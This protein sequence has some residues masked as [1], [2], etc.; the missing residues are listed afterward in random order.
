MIFFTSPVDE[1]HLT[2]AN[3][4]VVFASSTKGILH[5]N[6]EPLTYFL[7]L[8]SNQLEFNPMLA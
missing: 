8:H 5:Y 4:K 3:F 7:F 2:T 1:R 6:A